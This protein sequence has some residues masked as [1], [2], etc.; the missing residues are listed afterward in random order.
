M[1]RALAHSPW[2]QLVVGLVFLGSILFP[3]ASRDSIG[4][5]KVLAEFGAGL[6][7]LG[8]LV[9]IR[10]YVLARSKASKGGLVP[11]PEVTPLLSPRGLQARKMLLSYRRFFESVIAPM[12]R[13]ERVIAT[14]AIS[15][16]SVLYMLG[17]LLTRC[18]G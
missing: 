5:G 8:L 12:H 15:I 16:G 18:L 17:P 6:F 2:T 1:L 9:A 7:G 11:D 3:T 13:T 4:H 14:M 10:P